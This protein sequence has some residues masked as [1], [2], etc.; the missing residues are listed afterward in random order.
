VQADVR[1]LL[2]FAPEVGALEVFDP[3]G[4]DRYGEA[5]TL[6]EQGVKGLLNDI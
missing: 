1:L 4:T 5:C 2:S 6:I 3:Y